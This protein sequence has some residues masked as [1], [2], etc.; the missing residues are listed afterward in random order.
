MEKKDYKKNYNLNKIWR[1]IYDEYIEA[2]GFGETFL[3]ILKKQVDI[4][5]LIIEKAVTGDK[6]IQTFID[7]NNYELQEMQK[8][9]TEHTNF[10]KTKAQVEMALGFTF[11]SKKTSVAEFYSYIEIIKEK[12]NG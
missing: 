11:D 4:A 12:R 8:P 1:T 2:F 3:E 10:F 5:R 6:S 7:V 9:I